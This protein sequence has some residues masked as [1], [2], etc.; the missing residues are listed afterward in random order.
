MALRASKAD[1]LANGVAGDTFDVFIL[2][3]VGADR[4]LDR[5]STTASGTSPADA[6]TQAEVDAVVTDLT[7]RGE[8]LGYF[9]PATQ[10]ATLV[11][12]NAGDFFFNTADGNSMYRATA[13]GQAVTA[14]TKFVLPGA[15]GHIIGSSGT[16]VGLPTCVNGEYALLQNDVIGTGTA[17][18]PQY[19]KGI[20]KG[21]GGIWQL[22]ES[23]GSGPSTP[24]SEAVVIASIPADTWTN[25]PAGTSVTTP[26][27]IDIKDAANQ[28]IDLDRRVVAGV[29]QVISS[30]PLSNI[31]VILW[32]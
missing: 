20:Y 30:V 1:L 21:G 27:Y 9:D 6:L 7:T 25:V 12:Q 31:Q 8:N 19:P 16:Y 13:V 11:S 24:A 26:I 18:A 28:Y 3:V 10:P 4:Y 2:R 23:I 17:A 22:D 29:W 32:S 15:T 14:F 5:Q